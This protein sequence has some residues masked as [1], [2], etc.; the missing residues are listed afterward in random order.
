M[1]ESLFERDL[2]RGERIVWIGQPDPK[3]YLTRADLF[4][5]PFSLLWGGFTFYWEASV[6]GLTGSPPGPPALAVFGIPFVILALYFLVGR[7]FY[8]AWVKRNT[9]YALTARRALILRQL[10]GRSLD[11]IPLAT[12]P[13]IGTSVRPDGSGTVTFGPTGLFDEVYG[14]TGLTFFRRGVY[15]PAFYDIPDA[16]AVAARAEELRKQR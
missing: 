16:Q 11:A 2:A 4:L 9:H 5:I 8:Q 15:T 3:R 12:V 7:F 14:N 1:Y 10:R 13:S 6:L